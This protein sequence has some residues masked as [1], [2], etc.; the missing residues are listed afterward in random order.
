MA[1]ESGRG[2]SS[3][4]TGTRAREHPRQK[5]DAARWEVIKE[6]DAKKR[7]A[8]MNTGEQPAKE[9]RTKSN[10]DERRVIGE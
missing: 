10:N 5:C 6:N 2:C 3:I 4:V 1:A 9:T 7:R 8:G